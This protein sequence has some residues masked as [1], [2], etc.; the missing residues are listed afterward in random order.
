[1]GLDVRFP[2]LLSRFQRLT[3]AVPSSSFLSVWQ[4]HTFRSRWLCAVTFLGGDT[5]TGAMAA[6]SPRSA[7]GSA[8]PTNRAAGEGDSNSP[9]PRA[10]PRTAA[11]PA[12][13]Q[14]ARSCGGPHNARTGEQGDPRPRSGGWQGLTGRGSRS[15][16]APSSPSASPSSW[17]RWAARPPPPPRS[18][19][20]A[21]A[22]S[23]PWASPTPLRGVGTGQGQH[24][25]GSPPPTAPAP[26]PCQGGSGGSRKP[27]SRWQHRAEPALVAAFPQPQTSPTPWQP[28]PPSLPGCSQPQEVDEKPPGLRKPLL[29]LRAW[30]GEGLRRHPGTA[31]PGSEGLQAARGPS[32]R[33]L[34]PPRGHGSTD[35]ALAGPRSHV[36]RGG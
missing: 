25:A 18:S 10:G 29:I 22:G 9:T 35:R 14:A 27:S 33:R 5:T 12:D 2:P 8:R 13:A 16:A 11:E 34:E 1:M 17:S 7:R 36:P 3:E 4:L 32:S 20:A 26:Q 23:G 30:Q 31:T 28:R 15:R 6:A 21:A 19:S 24:G